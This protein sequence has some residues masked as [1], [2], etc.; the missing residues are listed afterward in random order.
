[1]RARDLVAAGPPFDPRRAG[2]AQH[3][4]YVGHGLVIFVFEGDG[5]ARQ[6]SH[7]V[8][9]R[10]RSASFSAWAPLLAEQPWLAHEV[11]HWDAE[12]EVHS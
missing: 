10:L 11:Y 9:D 6:L 7:L 4:V 12:V 2:L 3:S 8:N 5:V 1:M